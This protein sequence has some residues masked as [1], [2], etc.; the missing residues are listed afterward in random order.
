M[1][2]EGLRQVRD[3]IRRPLH[4]NGAGTAVAPLLDGRLDPTRRAVFGHTLALPPRHRRRA[5]GARGARR[6][7]RLHV[8]VRLGGTRARGHRD[9][10]GLAVAQRERVERDA[11]VEQIVLLLLGAVRRRRLRRRLLRRRLRRW[12]LCG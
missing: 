2:E 11:L 4:H 6:A 10:R 12:G 8:V 5:S 1:K 9:L 7:L 3:R